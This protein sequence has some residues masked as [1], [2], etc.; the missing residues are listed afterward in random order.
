MV[1]YLLAY[2]GQQINTNMTLYTK[3]ATGE[4]PEVYAGLQL[5]L[6]FGFKMLAGFCF[7]WLLIKTNPAGGSR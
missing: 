6:R 3:V 5:A 1:A 7:G 2:A 4:E